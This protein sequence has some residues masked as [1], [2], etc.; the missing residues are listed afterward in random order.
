M[1]KNS[2]GQI[3]AFLCSV[4]PDSNL[5][6]MLQLALAVSIPHEKYEHLLL[7]LRE[8]KDLI[9]FLQN[10]NLLASLIEADGDLDETEKNMLMETMEK[11]GLVVP[12]K[13]HMV[14]ALTQELTANLVDEI[15]E[16]KSSSSL[17]GKHLLW[18]M[19]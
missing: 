7:P 14:D 2:L 18:P 16:I 13:M 11:V 15:E 19:E 6:L 9:D 17:Q 8:N 12:M 10:D 4:P 3:M 5:R 1:N